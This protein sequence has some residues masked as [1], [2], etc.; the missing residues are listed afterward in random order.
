MKP[1]NNLIERTLQYI[2]E[3]ENIKHPHHNKFSLTDSYIK[4]ASTQYDKVE[5]PLSNAGNFIKKLKDLLQHYE[6]GKFTSYFRD[7]IKN[8][9]D[10]EIALEQHE[11]HFDHVIQVFFLGFNIITKWKYLVNK[12]DRN[13]DESNFYFFRNFF[14]SWFST[15][16]FHDHGY[17]IEE[18]RE[19]I[20][21]L[22]K[23][24]LKFGKFRY[25][26]ELKEI[27]WEILYKL[28]CDLPK[29]SNLSLEQFKKLFWIESKGI[30]DHGL[31]SANKYIEMLEEAKRDYLNS[32]EDDDLRNKELLFLDW[33]PNQNSILAMLL[34]NFKMIKF[35][36]F[37]FNCIL[38][39][40]CLDDRAI[41]PYLLMI[42]DDIQEWGR[43]KLLKN[44]YQNEVLD[45]ILKSIQLIDCKFEANLAII[46]LSHRLKN[47][48]K[49]EDYINLFIEKR[50]KK[51]K[52]NF[53]VEI[54]IPKKF[55][56]NEDLELT[57]TNS[58]CKSI[59]LPVSHRDG[60]VIQVD[61]SIE[62]EL[63]ATIFYR[64]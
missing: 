1:D 27:R 43:E 28:Y 9:I 44:L 56:K 35:E 49:K 2:N 57:T 26:F 8:E 52:Q 33:E 53:S 20:E 47:L 34:H 55:H 36:N 51:L 45:D 12:Y 63:F 11:A 60:Y 31:I 50:L 13:S 18:G 5:D 14:F 37:N 61:H 46:K 15:S 54:K 39:L 7:F 3:R 24:L 32:F 64:L 22:K 4:L 30:W 29:A 25:S 10:L 41:I 59:L 16:L 17:L 62:A 6:K 23:A 38:K 42:C 21:K 48:K 19:R 58:Y 40:S